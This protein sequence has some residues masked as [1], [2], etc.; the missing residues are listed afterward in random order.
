M[1]RILKKIYNAFIWIKLDL[2]TIFT[3]LLELPRYFRDWRSFS[4][5]LGNTQV[6]PMSKYPILLDRKAES[7]S[8][9]EYFWQDLLVAKEI[10]KQYE[11]LGFK[12][13]IMLKNCYDKE[14]NKDNEYMFYGIPYYDPY[15]KFLGYTKDVL[16]SIT[17][18]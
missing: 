16:K 8:L 12:N 14:I 2:S 1:I 6:W 13:I 11:F 10:I 18:R 4:R 17:F 7:A 3:S 15:Y 9:G 5:L